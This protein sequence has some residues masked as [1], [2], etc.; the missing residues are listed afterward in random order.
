MQ[1]ITPE[2]E[3]VLK[4][5]PPRLPRNSI[6]RER[7]LH[8]CL[9][10]ARA[11]PIVLLQ[12]ADGYGKSTLLLQWRRA[13]LESGKLVV[14]LTADVRDDPI[15]FNR[16]LGHAFRQAAGRS[17]AEAQ[18]VRQASRPDW[19]GG[20]LTGLLAVMGRA[21]SEV[22][23]MFDCCESLPEATVQDSL[24]YLVHNAPA[25]LRIVLASAKPLPWPKPA[26]PSAVIATLRECDL[27]LQA[28]EAAAIL[29]RRLRDR[30][31]LD[32]ARRL[33]Q[34]SEGWPMGAQLAASVIELGSNSPRVVESMIWL[35][36]SAPGRFVDALLDRLPID[37]LGFAVR[38]AILD[39][40]RADLC[41]AVVADG[42]A[43]THLAR[44]MLD[45]PLLAV[46]QNKD[47]SCLHPVA[48]TVL[49]QR[50]ARLPA[51]ER[52]GL[53]RRASTWYAQH[54]RPADAVR[55]AQHAGEWVTARKWQA[56]MLWS[57]ASEG[58]LVR[59]R[60]TLTRIP[61]TDVEA[62][63]DLRSIAAWIDVG[64]ERSARV[65][66]QS[67]SPSSAVSPDTSS[68]LLEALV[69]A[70]AAGYADRPGAIPGLLA[71]WSSGS[72]AVEASGYAAAYANCM[73]LYLLHEG[74]TARVREIE[75]RLPTSTYRHSPIVGQAIG[76]LLVG[77]SHLWEGY[78][79]RAEA[80]VRPALVQAEHVGGRRNGVAG[81]FAAVAATALY[82]RN[83]PDAAL[84][85]LADRLDTIRAT[86]IPDAILCAWRT[87]AMC[88]L[89]KG[90]SVQAL[91]VLCELHELA[92]ARDW[93][94]LQ[95]HSIADQI[96]IHALAGHQEIAS[97]LES[98][99]DDLGPVFA[100]PDLASFRPQ[101]DLLSAIA[102]AHALLGRG[103]IGA[104]ERHL[105]TAYALASALG[106]GHD[107]LIVQVLRAV[108]ARLQGAPLALR[109]L[110][111]ALSQGKLGGSRRLL[112]DSHPLALEMAAEL[113]NAS[114]GERRAIPRARAEPDPGEGIRPTPDAG[115]LTNMEM[116]VLAGWGTGLPEAVVAGDLA[117]DVAL[118]RWHLE[119]ACGK[120]AAPTPASA[121]AR[122]RLFGWLRDTRGHESMAHAHSG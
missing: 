16:A 37:L 103:D 21:R 120:L 95:L 36:G 117:I 98:R 67:R 80:V 88:A 116:R 113:R 109:M 63:V 46:G 3:F 60:E 114:A 83:Q 57:L 42:R 20:E 35:R 75:P 81:M 89:H 11:H 73:A 119:H 56:R 48:R 19:Q 49:L 86:A 61:V 111:E 38:C 55:H 66:A 47:W 105:L 72:A 99:L 93:P 5:T 10:G 74:Q 91:D 50:F 54:E 115:F 102:H 97:L 71:Q 45:T 17:R 15:R 112:Q 14:W 41:D 65:F 32:D 2:P 70:S 100:K 39:H 101:F 68:N 110:R 9:H 33:H 90:D 58:Q 79:D 76:R 53:H 7:L 1:A 28:E 118:L 121:I 23:L 62:D 59:A 30:L 31:A 94:R 29:L 78:P 82:E 34:A 25:N 69:A 92:I 44:L 122:A 106:R 12:A 4:A 85:M 22:V 87:L 104:A 84:A 40:L 26:H 13:F 51:A 52:D 24:A 64:N 77:L 96:R 8:W 43:T 18:A 108:V 107:L 6:R 27:R